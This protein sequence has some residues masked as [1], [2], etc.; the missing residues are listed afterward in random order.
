MPPAEWAIEDTAHET[1]CQLNQL[2]SIVSQEQKEVVQ[3][4]I[5]SFIAHRRAVKHLIVK[6]LELDKVIDKGKSAE[7]KEMHEMRQRDI[8]LRFENERAISQNSKL[9]SQ[10][11]DLEKAH[12]K[13]VT[14]LKAHFQDTFEHIEAQRRLEAAVPNEI[15]SLYA[16]SR[17]EKVKDR[18]ESAGKRLARK[19]LR[20]G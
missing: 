19:I 12:R 17:V 2:K 14:E 9:M 1:M 7:Q 11:S 8:T 15:E 6:V 4:A 3:N 10:M 18:K 16:V 5:D 13:E 20:L